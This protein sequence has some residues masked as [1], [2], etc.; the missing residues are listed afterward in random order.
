MVAEYDYRRADGAYAFTIYKGMPKAFLQGRRFDGGYGALDLARR[1]A[2]QDFYRFPGLETVMKGAGED[3]DMLYRLPE[4]LADMRE[5][6]D[7]VVYI[8]EG[9]KDTDA[10]RNRG[11]I[12]TTNPNGAKAWRTT[13][14]EHFG[15][16]H[17]AVVMDN[18]VNG[19]ERGRAITAALLPV[20]ASVVAIELP[21]LAINGD[22]SDWFDAGHSAA[23][24][25]ALVDQ[26]RAE[27]G[28]GV[29]LD[30]FRAY[31][32][33]HNYIYM[34]TGDFWPSTSVN[35]RIPPIA[36][37]NEAG[38]E[39]R[40]PA[41]QWL[42][43]HRAVEQMTWAPGEPQVVA[44]RI[45]LEGGWID[46]RDCNVFNLYRPPALRLG[47]PDKA[48][49]WLAHVQRVYPNE[50]EHI[51]NWLA[52]RRQR[53]HEKINHALVFGGAQGIGKDTILEPVKA[54][55]GSWNFIEV[56]PQQMLG[57]FN[58]FAKSVIL[59]ISEAR[60]LGDVDRFAFY[61]HS[62]IY[63]AAP[64]NV[65]RVDEKNLREHAVFNVCGVIITTNN[66]TNGIYLPADDRRHFVAWSDLI[67]DDFTADYWRTLYSWY[68]NGG[69]AHVAAYLA[70][71]DLSAFDPKS[72][73]PKTEA[74]WD[75]VASN[76]APEDAELADAIGKLGSPTAVTLAMIADAA[77]SDFAEWLRDRKNARKA[78]HKME[79][80]GYKSV[81][82][83]GA[84]S[85]RWK[86]S[87][88]D[89]VIYAR[90][91]LS[92]RDAVMAAEKLAQEGYC[93][94]S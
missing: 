69:S 9:E 76:S 84:K 31:M 58:G 8:C 42:D 64:P 62:K 77:D 41:N 94:R 59:R 53:P 61:E 71:K 86:V 44:H 51:V 88:K 87:G 10:G 12:A 78:P 60:D 49:P 80:G 39:R 43:R 28:R 91:E 47:D 83:P 26:A 18:D 4:L 54:A 56:T 72:P 32:P 67:R 22:L 35:S 17:V 85:G 65:L 23:D 73:P 38:E 66:K 1:D 45:V 2:P 19:R 11:L 24:L 92:V 16:R 6:P 74:F 29:R 46:R 14:T 93:E 33:S 7:D 3:A 57:R 30:D 48:G 63:T 20:A 81:R 21:G 55:I 68:A 36:V 13:F 79:E 34:P 52:H 50:A 15:G 25:L 70:S 27:G 89:V 5:R 75:I 90:K 82:N 37:A 40:I